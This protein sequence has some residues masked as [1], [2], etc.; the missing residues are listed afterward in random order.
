MIERDNKDN[1]YDHDDCDH[2]NDGSNQL[3]FRRHSRTALICPFGW[4]RELAYGPFVGASRSPCSIGRSP[5]RTHRLFRN[6]PPK[7]CLRDA[8]PRVEVGCFHPVLSEDLFRAGRGRDR[9]SGRL[10]APAQVAQ[11]PLRGPLVRLARIVREAARDLEQS[12]LPCRGRDGLLRV[13][14]FDF[15]RA[16]ERDPRL[17]SL[18]VRPSR[19]SVSARNRVFTTASGVKSRVRW[20]RSAS[21]Q[22]ILMS[23]FKVPGRT[24]RS[25][26]RISSATGASQET[27]ARIIGG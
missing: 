3:P 13:L 22:I 26:T 9:R 14:A 27:I 23:R 11:P 1:D 4:K 2:H 25:V 20:A 19:A 24:T 17:E 6:S 16:A 12:E 21:A 5:A 10:H 8:E 18:R 7:L 15:V